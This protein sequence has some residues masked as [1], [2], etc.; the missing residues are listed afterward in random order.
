M[1]IS[2]DPM[3]MVPEGEPGAAGYRDT[4]V[5]IVTE[6]GAERITDFPLGPDHNIILAHEDRDAGR[7]HMRM[8]R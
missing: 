6:A 3:L 1:V 5:M 8:G 7:L 2:V 4:D